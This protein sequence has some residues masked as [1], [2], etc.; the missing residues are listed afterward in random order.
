[1]RLV[2]LGLLTCTVVLFAGCASPTDAV[3]SSAEDLRGPESAAP[4]A[5]PQSTQ[6]TPITSP[7]AAA[8][9]SPSTSGTPRP[10]T[11]PART[12]RRP[13]VAL[14]HVDTTEKVVFLTIDDGA[15]ADPKLLAY[16]A[17]QNIPVTMFLTTNVASSNW[18]YWQG[19]EGVGSVQNHTMNH[20]FL[21]K[22][23]QAGAVKEICGANALLA[24]E[25]GQTP[26]MLRPPYGEYNSTTRT[27]AGECGIDYVVHWSVSLPSDKLIY[28]VGSSLRPGDIILTHFRWDLMD[29]L[30]TVMADIQAQ[31]YRVARLEDY[32]PPTAPATS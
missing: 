26:W 23:S 27:A 4:A 2:S 29:Y 30:P 32:L 10:S 19:M 15:V 21:N 28:Q 12:P 16:L 17:E 24:Q 5:S 8:S 11:D 25:T 18:T 9:A 22:T 1:M 31:G 14:N 6:P 13:A 3:L 7:S 20:P